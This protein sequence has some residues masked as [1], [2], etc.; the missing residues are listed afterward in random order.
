MRTGVR[1]QVTG[2]PCEQDPELW[3][4][5]ES[6]EED[7]AEAVA[8]C[9]SCPVEE[10]CGLGAVERGERYGI[11]GGTTPSDRGWGP[12]GVPARRCEDQPAARPVLE[13]VGASR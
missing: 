3:F 5:D 12:G 6:C 4:A 2:L 13:V 10:A 8:G 7:V 11:W 9:R 1:R